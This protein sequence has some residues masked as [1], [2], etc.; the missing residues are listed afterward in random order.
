MKNFKKN[1][2]SLT[3]RTPRWFIKSAREDK[4]KSL[5]CAPLEKH[6]K[7]TNLNDNENPS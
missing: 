6:N 4:D 7:S 5:K 1:P 2:N 3:Y